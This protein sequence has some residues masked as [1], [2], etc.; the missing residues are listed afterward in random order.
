MTDNDKKER[1]QRHKPA[2]G[3]IGDD[4]A[5]KTKAFCLSPLTPALSHPM[6]RGC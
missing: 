5:A 3:L 1:K 2:L 6:G 4:A